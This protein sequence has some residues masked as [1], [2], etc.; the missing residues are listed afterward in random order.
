MGMFQD[1][2]LTE[3]LLIEDG[4]QFFSCCR[5]VD[6]EVAVLTDANKKDVF[7]NSTNLT[8]QIWGR[9]QEGFQE[10]SRICLHCFSLLCNVLN[11]LHLMEHVMMSS[12][13]R[14]S[15]DMHLIQHGAVASIK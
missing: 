8:E 11:L 12:N 4:L 14:S 7:Y 2:S 9:L 3:T 1:E 15:H 5:N 10:K 13:Q 6:K